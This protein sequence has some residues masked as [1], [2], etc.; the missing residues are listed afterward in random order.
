LRENIVDFAISNSPKTVMYVNANGINLAQRDN[1][2]ID[3]LNFADCLHSDGWGVVWASRILGAPLREKIVVTDFF[4]DF[5]EELSRRKIS[6]YFLGG[7]PG[8]SKKAKEKLQQKIPSLII[9]GE[10]HGYFDIGDD[11]MIID[12]INN[13]K[14]NIL[15]IGMGTPRQEKW[16]Y[17][18]RHRLKVS[19][20]WSVGGLFDFVSGDIKRA[21]IWMLNCHLEWL[22]RLL[23]EPGRFWKR[24]MV[25]NLIFAYRV[26]KKMII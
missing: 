14:P 10:Y 3:I 9:L 1:K 15:V 19:L 6:M 12:E 4:I 2:F 13:C 8:V 25:G 7:R 5:C 23:Q 18:N 20:C 22:F 17:C 11:E 21:P 26:F 24:Y 16:L